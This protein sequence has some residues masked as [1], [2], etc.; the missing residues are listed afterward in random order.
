MHPARGRVLLIDKFSIHA[1]SEIHEHKLAH[2]L[3]LKPVDTF[4]FLKE[5][6][7]CSYY[8]CKADKIDCQPPIR[9]AITD[10]SFVITNQK[11]QTQ[12]QAYRNNDP[13]SFLNSWHVY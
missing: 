1:H 5:N 8:K 11:A 9:A 6:M 7:A 12:T 10:N 4:Y 13:L 3:T 2:F